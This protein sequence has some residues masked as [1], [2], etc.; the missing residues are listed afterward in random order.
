[1]SEQKDK[2]QGTKN[3]DGLEN[4][5]DQRQRE[6]EN[7]IAI[8]AAENEGLPVVGL[9]DE[10]PNWS[11]KAKAVVAKAPAKKGSGPVVNAARNRRR[12]A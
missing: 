3:V 1:M 10:R 5:G 7:T 9:G 6:K 12:K 4:P 2:T 8:D 11:D